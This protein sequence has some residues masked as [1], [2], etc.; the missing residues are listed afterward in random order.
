MNLVLR[1]HVP[2][3]NVVRLVGESE[4]E[5][6]WVEAHAIVGGLSRHLKHTFF[7]NH[8]KLSFD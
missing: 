7:L 2:D 8:Y 1:L 3:L 6:V 5:A 4:Q